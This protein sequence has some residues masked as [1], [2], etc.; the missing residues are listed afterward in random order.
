MNRMICRIS[1]V[2]IGVA[3]LAL[4][5]AQQ[6][7]EPEHKPAAQQPPEMTPEEKAQME[8]A[9]PGPIHEHMQQC[10]GEYTTNTRFTAPGAPAE[11]SQG[12]AK[13]SMSLDDRFLV[14]ESTGSMM[15]MPLKSMK[16]T[17]YN[18]AAKQFESVWVYTM[19]T[20]MLNMTGSSEDDGRTINWKGAYKE[21]DG[22]HTLSVQTH[23]DHDTLVE[24]I[25]EAD[26]AKDGP[27]MET[28]YTRKK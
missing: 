19:S 3:A 14:E 16:M 21:A 7:A 2:A 1:A 8:N 12:A 25:Y 10:V 23:V 13:L 5:A 22:E 17:G 28:T 20:G 24:K 4:L 27:I 26:G 6:P 15:G 9:M 18:N 11:Q